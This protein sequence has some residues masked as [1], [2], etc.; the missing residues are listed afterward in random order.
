[1]G[2]SSWNSSF[3]AWLWQRGVMTATTATAVVLPSATQVLMQGEGQGAASRVAGRQEIRGLIIIPDWAKQ[4]IS[5]ILL[6]HL[7]VGRGTGGAFVASDCLL[8]EWKGDDHHSSLASQ[9]S[10][11]LGHSERTSPGKL[12]LSMSARGNSFSSKGV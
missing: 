5:V 7:R 6:W 11:V 2:G 12:C 8:M 9:S 3:N 4:Q 10:L 1:M